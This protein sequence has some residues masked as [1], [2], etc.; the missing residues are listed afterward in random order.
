[1]LGIFTSTFMSFAV[2]S[3]V[4]FAVF[5][6]AEGAR[7]L[8]SSLEMFETENFQGK[9][10]WFRLFVSKVS[11]GVGNVFR[12]YADLR[13]TARLVDGEYLSWW[14]FAGGAGAL[15]AGPFVLYAA[16]VVI[17]KRRELAIYSG[18]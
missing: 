14:D 17:F 5:L 11:A 12:V 3:L 15:L 16:G 2:A 4:S 1:M 8:L 18:Q 6:M 7:F 10:E 9:T 13:P